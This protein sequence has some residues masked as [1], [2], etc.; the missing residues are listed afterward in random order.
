LSPVY[1]NKRLAF[2]LKSTPI[3]H[4]S[5]DGSRDN[6]DTPNVKGY[7]KI[8]ENS[9]LALEILG[10]ATKRLSESLRQKYP[11]I[12]WRGMAGMRD[13]IIH[14]YD[15]VDLKIVWD[16]VKKHIPTIKPQIK[17]IFSEY[18]T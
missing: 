18:E 8:N 16:V 11:D 7:N 12:P 4:N 2:D 15:T 10:E 1:S 17:Q 9:V 14:A 6:K 3:E 13:R 5:I